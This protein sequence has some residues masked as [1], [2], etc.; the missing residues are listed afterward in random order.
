[1]EKRQGI[2][3]ELHDLFERIR[4]EEGHQGLRR[5]D[6]VGAG[7]WEAL[8]GLGAQWLVCSGE[9]RRNSRD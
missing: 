1:M 3:E 4:N 7:R 2:K 5:Q 8:F 6:D 9:K